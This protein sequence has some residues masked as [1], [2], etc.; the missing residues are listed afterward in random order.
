MILKFEG[1]FRFLSN[2]YPCEIEHQGIRYPSVEHFY[3]A[4]KVTD[5]Q[6]IDGRYITPG[7]FREMIAKIKEPGVVKKIGKKV[8]LRKDWD[9]KKLEFMNWAVREKFKND[10]LKQLLLDT[11]SSEL[12]EGNSWN[13]TFWGVFDGKGHNHLGK[14]LMAVRDELRG[15]KRVGLEQILDKNFDKN[16]DINKKLD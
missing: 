11:G 8:K 16:R 5:E 6:F 4:M 3:I 7:D 1:R 14:I 9:S 2:F 13:D 12:I 15:Q 10:K